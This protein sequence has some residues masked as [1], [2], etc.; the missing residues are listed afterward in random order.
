M[1]HSLSTVL[2]LVAALVACARTQESVRAPTPSPQDRELPSLT[3]VDVPT[4]PRPGAVK[5]LVAPVSEEDRDRL[6]NGL[7]AADEDVAG[8]PAIDPADFDL[9]MEVNERVVF[10]KEH[11]Q[12]RDAEHFEVYLT[13]MG[14]YEDFIRSQLRGRGMP[15]DLVYLALVESGFSPRAYSRAH[16]VG[17][18]QFI[19]GTATRY[20]LEV[21]T[22]VDER[23]DPV[24]ATEAALKHLEELYDRFGSWYLAAAAYNGG[25]N[26][27]E[28]VL[29][30]RAGGQRGD[31]AIFWRI[32]Q[33]LPRETREY[34][35]KILA[36]AI[37]AKDPERYGFTD[38][39]PE[40]PESSETVT[41][42]DATDLAVIAEAAGVPQ[43]DVEA[44]NP[45]FLRGY[46]PPGRDAEVR[47]P[48]GSATTFAVA[49]ERIAPEDR[50]RFVEH[51][52]DRGETLSHIARR[53]RTSLAELQGAN[54]LRNPHRLA[55][56]QRLVI[57]RRASERSAPLG[58]NGAADGTV[59]Y[60]VLPGDTLWSIG[61]QHGVTA[62]QLQQWNNLS[63]STIH[64]GDEVRVRV[65]R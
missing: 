54:D 2:P 19:A 52:V 14:R 1:R 53:Y 39:V 32:A 42:P 12:G 35:P 63:G 5:E 38:V 59:V 48:K 50:V 49:Y 45:Q 16:A 26:R 58:D 17:I 62:R 60:R 22:F 3:E 21:S 10:W 51:F 61:R 29:R 13:R 25:A 20:D 27:V 15:E 24:K 7:I 30:Q 64:P 57:P 47:V 33:F 6:A 56:N 40:E 44:L 36:A 65:D 18:W 4:L 31:D 41:I 8:E 23:R 46:T 9:P 43:E 34:V 37:L 55:V 28:R 11:F